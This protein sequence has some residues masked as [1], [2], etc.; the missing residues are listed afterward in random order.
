[1]YLCYITQETPP[2]PHCY[3]LTPMCNSN[4]PHA[5]LLRPDTNVCNTNA[6]H[7]RVYSPIPRPRPA[8]HHMQYGIVMKDGRGLGTRLKIQVILEL[9]SHVAEWL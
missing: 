4:G 9:V 8:L 5:A 7:G 3:A 1:M 6:P 2:M